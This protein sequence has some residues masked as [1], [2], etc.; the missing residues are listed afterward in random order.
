MFV[1]RIKKG[2]Y[3]PVIDGRLFFDSLLMTYRFIIE[4]P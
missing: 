1:Q 2:L 3:S 4:F